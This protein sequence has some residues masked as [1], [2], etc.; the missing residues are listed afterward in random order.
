MIAVLLIPGLR[1]D[2]MEPMGLG[3]E[4]PK[5]NPVQS[6]NK[7][8]V[9]S[10]ILKSLGFKKEPSL[11]MP[12]DEQK[13]Q[14]LYDMKIDKP[15]AEEAN[16]NLESIAGT[17]FNKKIPPS[18]AAGIMGNV[19]QETRLMNDNF[20]NA[21]GNQR[22]GLFHLIDDRKLEFIKDQYGDNSTVKNVLSALKK[23]NGKNLTSREY[24]TIMKVM[25][26]DPDFPEKNIN[27][28][29]NELTGKIK[30][31]TSGL[32]SQ[33]IAYFNSLMAG[34]EETSPE[35]FARW[36]SDNY[37]RP[38]QFGSVENRIAYAKSYYNVRQD[39]R[40]RLLVPPTIDLD[41]ENKV[42]VTLDN[43]GRG[44]IYSATRQ[45]KKGRWVNFPMIVDGKQLSE[46]NAWSHYL[47]TGKHLGIFETPSVAAFAAK[48]DSKN[49]NARMKALERT[50]N[51]KSKSKKPK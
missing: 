13:N 41:K 32:N 44:T 7:D 27:Y 12:T 46:D 23:R 36:F 16:R 51:D 40:G 34:T 42:W 15:N 35:D 18:V 17:M 24:K 38:G 3:Y 39:F 30:T 31:T 4:K 6:K 5:T 26:G 21:G 48:Q 1:G 20:F 43:G 22:T 37:E 33:K 29:L 47:K 45:D 9:I 8:G 50:Y 14:M 19:I 11:L 28:M 10:S 49:E 2:N 25:Q